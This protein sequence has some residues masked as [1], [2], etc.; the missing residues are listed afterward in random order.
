MDDSRPGYGKM[1]EWAS[2]LFAVMQHSQTYSEGASCFGYTFGDKV[3]HPFC[4]QQRQ[5]PKRLRSTQQLIP[6]RQLSY[7]RWSQL[8]ILHSRTFRT[9]I[10]A[11]TSK[12]SRRNVRHMNPL[13]FIHFRV[14]ADLGFV[15]S[16]ARYSGT[17]RV[18]LRVVTSNLIAPFVF[19]CTFLNAYMWDMSQHQVC[20]KQA[21]H[22]LELSSKNANSARC[23][24]EAKLVASDQTRRVA[25]F[26]FAFAYPKSMSLSRTPKLEEFREFQGR[27]TV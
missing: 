23:S 10:R 25:R 21:M 24:K 20:V 16:Q 22:S 2:I 12:F 6:V 4:N 9:S 1:L 5:I 11:E 8:A 26:V 7:F 3:C 18:S 14:L 13:A 17:F 27:K 15:Q 19:E